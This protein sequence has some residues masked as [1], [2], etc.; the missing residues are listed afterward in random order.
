MAVINAFSIDVEDWFQ[1]SAFAPHI[2]P[3]S[4]HELPCRVERNVDLLLAMLDE[5]SVHATFFTLGWIAARYPR[6]VRRI[7]DAGH[8]L[9]SH[10]YA[11]QRASDQSPEQFR[12][13]LVHARDVL[14][15]T[16][17]VRV[18]GYR[19]PSFSIGSANAWAHEVIAD[20]GHRYSSSVFPVAHDH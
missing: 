4:W 1:V 11:H 14:E 12:A 17:G 13:D 15:Q 2:D 10:G 6:T 7:V 8:E 20:I 19:A 18:S 3:S 5:A 16:G 9:A